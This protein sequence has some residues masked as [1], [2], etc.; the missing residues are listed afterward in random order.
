M[1]ASRFQTRQLKV[2]GGG[3]CPA[4]DVLRLIIITMMKVK[5]IGV[6]FIV[7]EHN[8]FVYAREK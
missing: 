1:D 4:A 3:L 2:H 6:N 5:T 7:P 8:I